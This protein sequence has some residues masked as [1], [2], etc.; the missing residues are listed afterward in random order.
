MRLRNA[1]MRDTKEKTMVDKYIEDK[2]ASQMKIHK[3]FEEKI[4]E[5]IAQ[6]SGNKQTLA[7]IKYE[8]FMQVHSPQKIYAERIEDYAF[9]I[10]YMKKD[11]FRIVGMA[12]RKEMRGKGYGTILLFRCIKFCIRRNITKIETRTLSGRTFYRDKAGAKV[13]GM[14]DGDYLME[15]Q[16]PRRKAKEE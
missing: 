14:K 10:G 8:R 7:D 3:G 13:V 16:L 1:L 9:L 2:G 6:A 15:I 11:S 4:Y 5:E 12:T